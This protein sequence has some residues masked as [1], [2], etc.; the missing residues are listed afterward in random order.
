MKNLTERFQY[1]SQNRLT[2]IT[3]KR[4]SGQDLH[5]G[6]SYDALGRMTSK[7]AVTAVNGTPQVSS[8]FSQPAFD[9]T[10][11]HA[12]ASAQSMSDLFPTTAQT[13]TYTGFD[14]AD[15]IKQGND[16]ICYAYGYDH[17]RIFMEEHIGSIVRTKR[18][19]G[20]C[21]YVTETTGNTTASQWLTYLTGSTGVYAVVVTANNANTIHYILKDNLG[22]W[23]A[24]TSSSGTVEQRLS[25]DAW[26]NLRNPNTWSGSFS[27]TPMFDRGF[28]GHEHLYDFG[29]INMNGRMYDPITSSF[30]SVDQYV[31]SPENAQGFNRYAYCSNN[32]LRYVDPSGELIWESVLVG[33]FIG[34]FTNTASRLMSGSVNNGTQFWVAAGIGAV[35]GGLGGA[36]GYG[37]GLGAASWL[38]EGSLIGI[39]AA[40][41]LANGFVSASSAAWMQGASFSQGLWAGVKA[42]VIGEFSG[43]LMG[44]LEQLAQYHDEMQIFR[45]GCAQLEIEAG[46]PIPIE[47]QNDAFLLQA[48][49][50]WY[51]DAPYDKLDAFSVEHVP[52]DKMENL[53]ASKAPASTS[54]ISK[55]GMLTGRSKMYF[56]NK[57]CFKSAK[58]LFYSMGHEFVHVSQFAVL[59]G[60][61]KWVYYCKEFYEMLDYYAYGYEDVLRGRSF[62]GV[63]PDYLY[64]IAKKPWPHLYET[65]IYNPLLQYNCFSWTKNYT[66][67]KL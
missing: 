64:S 27:G 46:D 12:L 7:Q 60:M 28:T 21:E 44:G 58:T 31:G 10:K 15:K 34:A 38:G 67:I 53:I 6:V 56:Y 47:K 19:V 18:Y 32:P 45:K 29:L 25:F 17:Q 20:N 55:G 50:T 30:L 65:I 57:L 3:L 51:P 43:A 62:Y 1:D 36:A 26:G 24:I 66:F 13:V 54:P 9:A 11:V 5:C 59:E 48:R 8:V 22:S 37:A 49:E 40:S 2:G 14:K 39:G 35:S 63:Q 41:G 33:A 42:G 61:P 23:T 4:S 16:S 52:P